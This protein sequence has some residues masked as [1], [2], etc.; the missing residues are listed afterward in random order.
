MTAPSVFAPVRKL[1]CALCKHI[2]RW[3]EKFRR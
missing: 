1:A 3:L 2:K